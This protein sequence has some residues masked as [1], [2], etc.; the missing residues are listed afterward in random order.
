MESEFGILEK[1]P[2]NCRHGKRVLCMVE[3]AMP[4]QTN[5]FYFYHCNLENIIK[6]NLVDNWITSIREMMISYLHL[7]QNRTKAKMELENY[8]LLAVL[9]YAGSLAQRSPAMTRL[10]ALMPED[11]FMNIIQITNKKPAKEH[12]LSGG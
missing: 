8:A 10:A 2:L 11:N 3:H 4:F 1:L 5:S 6:F 7:S 12:K 9:P